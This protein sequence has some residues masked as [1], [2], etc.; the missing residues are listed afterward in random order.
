[1]RDKG[2]KRTID[3]VIGKLA[4]GAPTGYSA[5]G[6]VLEVGAEVEGFLS[7]IVFV[8]RRRDNK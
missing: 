1:M 4:A 5:S 6:E 7:V 2:V 8:R 3:R